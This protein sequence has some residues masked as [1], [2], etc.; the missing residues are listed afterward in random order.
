MAQSII[1]SGTQFSR[2]PILIGVEI[3]VGE[4]L[5]SATFGVKIW[6]GSKTS[7]P[8]TNDF[9]IYAESKDNKT[10]VVDLSDLINTDHLHDTS[11]RSGNNFSP[12]GELMWIQVS[13][14]WTLTSGTFNINP[15]T[16]AALDGYHRPEE[17]ANHD[18]DQKIL[19]SKPYTQITSTQSAS[20]PIT[21]RGSQ[22]LHYVTTFGEEVS[23]SP[24]ND[25]NESEE[26]V[27]YLTM[28]P[29][30]V[31]NAVQEQGDYSKYFVEFRD[32]GTPT[33]R[34][35]IRVNDQCK[36]EPIEILFINKFGVLDQL[37]CY[38]R[39]D[40]QISTTS[41]EF[42]SVV[43]LELVTGIPAPPYIQ[44]DRTS[45]QTS[46]I[47]TQSTR[48][49]TINTGFLSE[50]FGEVISQIM[51]SEKVWIVKD[52]VIIPV[53]ATDSGQTLQQQINERLINYTLAFKYANDQIAN[54]R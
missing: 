54:I 34:H 37:T 18:L 9:T 36:H 50:G 32:G 2:S 17:N 43:G 7:V 46:K 31:E 44:Y 30:A 40:M 29:T 6:T 23:L 19:T 49:I 20:L 15:T 28:T 38:G 42:K 12:V 35:E 5:I 22:T 13:P 11:V 53:I 1:P 3:G 26:A 21:A 52:D 14:Q 51:E 25:T 33:E 45:H 27:Q 39:H 41:R 10:I 24:P 8:S 48:S 4:I 16:F 47:D